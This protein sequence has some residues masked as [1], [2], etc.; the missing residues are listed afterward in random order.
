MKLNRINRT[1]AVR[2]LLLFALFNITLLLTGCTDTWVSSANGIISALIPAINA[3]LAIL[4]AF[5]IGVSPEALAAIQAWGTSAQNTLTN[6]V[7]PA[8]DAYNTAAA[9]TQATLL[10]EI[11]AALNSIV[12]SLNT[13][14]AA[15]HVTDP[16]SQAKIMA[17]FAV[18]QAFMV[19]L[20]NL[21]PV[22]KNEVKDPV[23]AH[24]LVRSVK[25]EKEFRHEFNSLTKE[26]GAQYQI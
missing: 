11:D 24:E 3:A 10:T 1:I 2:C 7:K 26:Y 6:V 18:V 15:I 9:A 12:S 22:L 25:S 17:I 14:L 4:A 21:I 13:A 19:S 20:I 23:K 8:I 5:G 16:A